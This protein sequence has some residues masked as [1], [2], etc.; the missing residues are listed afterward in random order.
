MFPLVAVALNGARL[1]TEHPQVPRSPEEL[2]RE[3]RASVE[4]WT[5][6]TLDSRILSSQCFSASRT[7]RSWNAL[8]GCFR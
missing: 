1:A 4:A 7:L 5:A 6:T 3:A 2:A 8:I